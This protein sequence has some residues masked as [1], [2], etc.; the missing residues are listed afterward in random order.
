M[1]DR[2]TG[3]V[4]S[5]WTQSRLFLRSTGAIHGKRDIQKVDRVQ[6]RDLKSSPGT[7]EHDKLASLVAAVLTLA[8]EV[9]QTRP[10]GTGG[11]TLKGKT[12]RGSG[13]SAHERRQAPPAKPQGAEEDHA[14][15]TGARAQLALGDLG[16]ARDL[17]TT[18]SG[19]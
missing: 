1:T 2:G 18:C 4:D 8:D 17:G 10:S 11:E 15:V 13:T 6:R 7:E 5:I 3:G 14:T 12:S 19:R 16:L 9:R